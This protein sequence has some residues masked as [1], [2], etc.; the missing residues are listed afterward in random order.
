M[1]KRHA[2]RQSSIAAIQDHVDRHMRN[3]VV[4]GCSRHCP[5]LLKRIR[6]ARL[7]GATDAEID[8]AEQVG[9]TVHVLVKGLADGLPA[10]V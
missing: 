8:E 2:S 3:G 9:R 6:A 7:L 1:S 5:I 10:M 4:A